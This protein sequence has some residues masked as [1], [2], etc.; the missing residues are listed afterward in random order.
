MLLVSKAQVT[1][2]PFAHP[3]LGRL[4]TPRHYPKIEATAAA[5]WTWAADNDAFANFHEGRYL[6]MLERIRGL[7]DADR[8]RT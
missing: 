7:P 5:G 8:G 2:D 3:N 1:L 4:I 6:Q